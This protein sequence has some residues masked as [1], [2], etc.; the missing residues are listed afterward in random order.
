MVIEIDLGVELP[1]YRLTLGSRSFD[2]AQCGRWPPRT[3]TVLLATE[4]I[5]E[6]RFQKGNGL[7]N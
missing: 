4:S 1:V 5:N 2:K 3:W 6:S 7:Q